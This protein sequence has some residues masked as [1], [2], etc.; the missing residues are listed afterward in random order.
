M[1]S[2]TWGTIYQNF[3]LDLDEVY[4]TLSQRALFEEEE[5]FLLEMET[6]LK[7]GRDECWC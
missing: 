2:T 5:K 7:V 4:L 6:S 3:V 1:K